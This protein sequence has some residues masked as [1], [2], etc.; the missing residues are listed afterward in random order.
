MFNEATCTDL[1]GSVGF[2]HIGFGVVVSRFRNDTFKGLVRLRLTQLIVREVL[3]QATGGEA[4]QS[5]ADENPVISDKSGFRRA[6]E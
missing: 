1:V 3:R 5:L 2:G 4:K 6:S